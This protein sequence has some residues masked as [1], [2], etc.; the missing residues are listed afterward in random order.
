MFSTLK[1]LLISSQGVQETVCFCG[2]SPI[3]QS[4]SKILHILQ[5]T[6]SKINDDMLISLFNSFSLFGLHIRNESAEHRLWSLLEVSIHLVE[7]SSIL[8]QH[9]AHI[10]IGQLNGIANHVRSQVKNKQLL[11]YSL[12]CVCVCVLFGYSNNTV[13]NHMK[14]L[15]FL[16]MN[17]L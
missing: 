7:E 13:I 2:L 3:L 10:G 1:R 8:H 17:C 15:I 12:I 9:P 11:S 16:K 5:S 14:S 4:K 6:R